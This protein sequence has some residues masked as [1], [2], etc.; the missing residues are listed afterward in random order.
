[1]MNLIDSYFESIGMTPRII[2]EVENNEAIKSLVG[3][4]LGASIIPRCAVEELP[5]ASQLRVLHLKGAPLMRQLDLVTLDAQILPKAIRELAASLSAALSTL[6]AKSI[7]RA[8][9]K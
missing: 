1:M 5:P 8:D 7:V 6:K 9:H 4:G 3:V 2:M